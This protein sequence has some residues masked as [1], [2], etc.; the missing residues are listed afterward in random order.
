MNKEVEDLE[1]KIYLARSPYAINDE[2]DRISDARVFVSNLKNTADGLNLCLASFPAF[3]NDV[4][5]QFTFEALSHWL[6][7]RYNEIP[8]PTWEAIFVFLTQT[9]I[10]QINKFKV[11]TAQALANAQAIFSIRTCLQIFPEVILRFCELWKARK[12]LGTRYIEYLFCRL[13]SADPLSL[14]LHQKVVEKIVQDGALAMMIQI[15]SNEIKRGTVVGYKMLVNYSRFADI[16]FID[17]NLINKLLD[18][19]DD[20]ERGIC[21]AKIFMSLVQRQPTIE[22][23]ARIVQLLNLNQLFV[24]LSDIENNE[25]SVTSSFG[26]LLSFC[27]FTFDDPSLFTLAL[28]YGCLSEEIA[29]NVLSFINSFCIKHSENVQT[30]INFAVNNLRTY[31]TL[32]FNPT[33][34]TT[35][36]ELNNQL[37]NNLD[38]TY[39]VSWDITEN[40]LQICVTCFIINQAISEQVLVS[41]LSDPNLLNDMALLTTILQIMTAITKLKIPLAQIS[42]ILP[43]FMPLLQLPPNFNDPQI[44]FFYSLYQFLCD[45]KEPSI[46]I[47][48]NSLVHPS[49]IFRCLIPFVTNESIYINQFQ[50]LMISFCNRNGVQV[51]I[52][53]NDFNLFMQ[54]FSSGYGFMYG[55]LISCVPP[56]NKPAIVQ[57]T[58]LKL[59]QAIQQQQQELQQ[60]QMTSLIQSDIVKYSLS[61]LS[62]MKVPFEAQSLQITVQFVQN[63]LQLVQSDDSLLAKAI[64][65]I[66]SL[67]LTGAQFLVQIYPNITT[68]ESLTAI[69]NLALTIRKS[70]TNSVSQGV[71]DPSLQAAFDVSWIPK[72]GEYLINSFFTLSQT[73]SLFEIDELGSYFDFTQSLISFISFE[74][75]NIQFQ[76]IIK[77]FNLLIDC[78][79]RFYDSS[80]MNESIFIFALA[81]TNVNHS[82]IPQ[83]LIKLVRVSLNFLFTKDINLLSKEWISVIIRALKFYQKFNEIAQSIFAENILIA[84]QIIGG[85]QQT[86]QTF[87][88]MISTNSSL[89]NLNYAINFFSEIYANRRFI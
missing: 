16:S 46:Q 40:Y 38:N 50:Q 3:T 18:N 28:Q 66:N 55:A 59:G 23:K 39:S 67:N 69:S 61:V 44:I 33:P 70:V 14:E 89:P 65:G 62:T 21:V 58:I 88:N 83:F 45:S 54:S 51:Q 77:L 64:R 9:A 2:T 84:T 42:N 43:K 31:F 11:F 17:E 25:L 27:G 81:L 26:S 4:A 6:E 19:L 37:N 53:E 80:I 36:E 49:Q 86:A 68:I 22:S 74:I 41:N 82:D 10:S 63:M 79:N 29:I 52:T 71:T 13:S 15:M 1:F 34:P 85:S 12:A 20:K 75:G 48:I 30:V 87:I 32:K 56:E 24:N 8:Q 76:D 7:F 57:Q 35:K 47:V 78:S 5:F 73:A 72:I 60:Q